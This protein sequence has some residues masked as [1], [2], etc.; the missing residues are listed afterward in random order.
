MMAERLVIV[1]A[2]GHGR[3]C[4]DVARAAGFEVAG[5]CDQAKARGET[6]GDA[7][8]LAS[9]IEEL[10][11]KADAADTALFIALGD[12]ARRMSL[13]GE[14][15]ERGFGLA[16]LVHPSAV[17]SPSVTV[18]A[19]SVIVAG[20]IVNANAKIGEGCIVNTASSL[21]HDNQ[22]APGV[23]ICPGVHAAGNV[24]F[25]ELAFVGMGAAI[26]PNIAIG[27]RAVVAAGAVVTR[28]VDA[29]QMVAGVPAAIVA[30]PD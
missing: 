28:D 29:D 12:N 8:I 19:G 18:G 2:G 16:T 22:L 4:A 5:F 15:R 6:V 24:R 13:I 9:S 23:Q 27:A 3:V 21:D 7:A 17:L 10:S 25:G 11:D 26:V 20:A 30:K 14:V 1:G